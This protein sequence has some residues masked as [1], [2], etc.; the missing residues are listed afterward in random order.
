MALGETG[1]RAFQEANYDPNQVDLG[2]VLPRAAGH[3]AAEFLGDKI[4]LGGML[5]KGA[6]RAAGEGAYPLV[7]TV[8]GN[9]AIVAGK[10]IPVEIF[11]TVLERDAAKLALMDQAARDEY[12]NTAAQT[13][14][15]GVAGAPAGVRSY[16]SGK[17]ETQPTTQLQATPEDT[18][19]MDALNADLGGAVF[20][21]ETLVPSEQK[22]LPPGVITV[23]NNA[24]G[25]TVI[26]ANAGPISGAAVT[27][28]TSGAA[29]Q[30]QAGSI[31]GGV[32]F[33]TRQA[34]QKAID[35][36]EDGDRLQIIPHPRVQGAFAT[37]EKD[38]FKLRAVDEANLRRQQL[39]Q[40]DGN[41][42]QMATTGGQ[43]SSGIA[44]GSAGNASTV[45]GIGAGSGDAAAS[46]VHGRGTSM[47][48]GATDATESAL[49]GSIKP[50]QD[51]V[52]YLYSAGNKVI[53]EGGSR[54]VADAIFE[55][56]DAL[57]RSISAI[58]QQDPQTELASPQAQPMS[59]MPA[60]Q[61]IA[62]QR[63]KQ[64]TQQADVRAQ[65]LAQEEGTVSEPEPPT[66]KVPRPMK[67]GGLR[68]AKYSDAQLQAVVDNE[69]VPATSR[70]AAA[71]EIAWRQSE[72]ES[73]AQAE[74][75][76]SI[77][78][79][80][81]QR[82]GE[83]P[84][85]YQ[86]R[87]A[88]EK[89]AAKAQRQQQPQTA[90]EAEDIAAVRRAIKDPK[91]EVSVVSEESMPDMDKA[92]PRQVS[93]QSAT[94]LRHV[95]KIFGKKI[96]FVDGMKEDGFYRSGNKIYLSNKSSVHHVRVLGHEM[97]HAMKRQNRA[98]YDK[99]IEAVGEIATDAQLTSQF[100]DYFAMDAKM[101]DKTDAEIAEW[102]TD[103]ANREM[104]LEE[105]MADLSG[106]R[107]AE[108]SFWESVFTKIDAKY[109][110]EQAKG[111]IAKLRLALINALNKLMSLVKGGQFK[112][113]TRV[114]E[115]L[116]SIREALA[117]G[118]ADYAKAVKDKQL[119]EDGVGAV[120]FAKSPGS[121]IGHKRNSDG[122]YVGSPDWVGASPSQVTML[123]KKLHSLAIEGEPGRMWYERSSAAILELVNGDKAE[124]EKIVQLIA[125]YSPSNAVPGN[126]TMAIKAYYQWKQGLPI[127]V[128]T[129]NNDKK[130]NELLY[131]GREWSGI[132]TNSFYQNLMQEI[133]PSKNDAG[134]ATMDMWMALAFD[135]GMKTVDQGPKYG[136]MEREI[137]RLARELKWTPHQIQAAIW[138]AMK[139]RIDP[140]RG[141][142]TAAELDLGWHN[143]E[144]TAAWKNG[145]RKEY[146]ERRKKYLLDRAAGKKVVPPEIKVAGI[147]TLNSD[148]KK[149]HYKLAH[150]MGMEY[151]LRKS[152]IEESKYD[153]SDAIK[154][155]TAQMSWEATPG[156]S[157]MVLPGIH[158]APMWQQME[159]LAAMQK[160]LT[161]ADGNDIIG[162][163]VGLAM[164]ESVQ[165][166]SGWQGT[167]TV[168][169]QDGIVVPPNSQEGGLVQGVA[170]DAINLVA[171]IRGLVLNQE[172][173]AWHYP[174]HTGSI[175]A[176]NGIEFNVGRL[177]TEEENA[178]L[179]KALSDELGH[180]LSP[181]IPTQDGQGFRVLN[182][183]DEKF[184][185]M[186]EFDDGADMLGL[187][188]KHRKTA[189][190]K[191]QKV[192]N[193][194][195]ADAV[196]RAVKAQPWQGD[197]V[198]HVRFETDGELRENDWNNSSEDYRERIREAVSGIGKNR[199]AGRPDIFE[200][201]DNDLRQ[202][203]DAVNRQ[204]AQKYGWAK[205][206]EFKFSTR[207][208]RCCRR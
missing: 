137:Q 124:A 131:Q 155:R 72:A 24:G 89:N 183:P 172:G 169:I 59:E 64:A 146:M 140:I 10:E 2:Q 158:D 83:S 122:R 76:Q 43:G 68:A 62:Q 207:T 94:F 103:P 81:R 50:L 23:P 8:A 121:D 192:N 129:G 174:I 58:S 178:I 39:E 22:M 194:A 11:Q 69:S 78:K 70:R 119:S 14:L 107:W 87:M 20:N 108:S 132:K 54:E 130:A 188:G 77:G 55:Q 179:Y 21:N 161:D 191:S 173:V 92:T 118:F 160:A 142:L 198:E 143:A 61:A 53:S 176:L 197:V 45:S 148:R 208:I 114:A 30:L 163:E 3:A 193:E 71:A 100:K 16:L 154:Q 126:T 73:A 60:M 167:S 34:A 196:A 164:A 75:A 95:A 74:I 150:K 136:F 57:Q 186:G 125:I 134:K 86:Y 120:K 157:T 203:A 84:A 13:M 165:G 145:G 96:V 101:M 133:D 67:V 97:L 47:A 185:L 63:T 112:V 5:G 177:L 48:M 31:E 98:S 115:H 35:G 36:R 171:D 65:Q 138:T 153:F 80:S 18:A 25:E 106:N 88:A 19:Q 116:E 109:G 182:F 52:D 111:I 93:K 49:R 38:R 27:A 9:M 156:K 189:L 110:S 56:A 102:L 29:A 127:R 200:W 149:D 41:A 32:P 26:D 147:D 40:E 90:M 205:Q 170:R 181:P 139:G 206:G 199:W 117:T 28:V 195:F 66:V 15:F 201:I 190:Q 113:D 135:Y 82:A 166:F 128:G 152:D 44:G 187:D 85:D 168:G 202:K 7:K 180:T 175:N 6:Y 151:D 51:R 4:L 105:M 144:A 162:K 99:L 37:V 33:S 91:A 42:P 17:R 104:I 141:E 1:S 159:Y 184:A 12:I 123:R 46:S 204:F 79:M